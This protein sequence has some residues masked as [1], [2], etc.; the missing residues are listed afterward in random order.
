VGRFLEHSRIFYFENGGQA[1]VY[2][3]SADWMSRNLYERVEVIFPVKDAVIRERV[4]TE[5]LGVYLSDTCKARMLRSNGSYVKTT[6]RNGLAVNAQ[7]HLLHV[8]ATADGAQR[9][10]MVTA[11]ES[12]DTTPGMTA[13]GNL[14]QD[15]NDTGGVTSDV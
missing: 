11:S 2:L 8:A 6:T 7:E 9:V 13:S 4:C 10:R 5:I 3:G 15:L 14:P 12:V 1:E